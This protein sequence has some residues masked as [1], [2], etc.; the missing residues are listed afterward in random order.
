MHFE[1]LV[2]DSSGA[3]L[4]EHVLPKI[5]NRDEEAHTWRVLSYKGIGRLPPGLKPKSNASKRILLDQLPRLMA[6]YGRSMPEHPVVIV[7]D[8]DDYDCSELLKELR[9]R[10]AGIHPAPRVLFRL[11]I[12]E[13]EAWYLGDRAAVIAAYP[14]AKKKVLDKYSQD[15]VCGTWEVL[16]D[17]IE[18]GGAAPIKRAGWPRPGEVKH[19]WAREIGP[20]MDVENNVSPSFCK[21][22]DGLRRLIAED[23]A[24]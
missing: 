24:G 3:V 13:I 23:E 1:V 12:E 16:A 6:G 20:H 9:A 11:A 2:E 10:H 22:R 8:S 21:L 19:A 14:D 7:L 17:A 15:A 18:P 5:L 4:L